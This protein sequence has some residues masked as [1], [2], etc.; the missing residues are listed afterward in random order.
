MSRNQNS[1]TP[2]IYSQ[3]CNALKSLVTVDVSRHVHN[4]ERGYSS[5][6][7]D[8]VE[9]VQLDPQEMAPT[10]PKEPWQQGNHNIAFL[11]Y[12]ERTILTNRSITTRLILKSLHQEPSVVL[13]DHPTL[14]ARLWSV[15][16]NVTILEG[17]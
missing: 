7:E 1:K 12:G 5:R 13:G 11:G 17:Q 4:P 16:L 9:L 15:D 8:S 6:L 10:S 2:Y 3:K 14:L